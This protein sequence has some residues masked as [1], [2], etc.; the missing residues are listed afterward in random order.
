MRGYVT[1]AV[2]DEKY[3][4]LAVNLLKSY[5]LHTDETLPFA[6]VCDRENKYTKMFDKTVIIKNPSRTYV[7]KLEILNLD[8]FNENDVGVKSYI[9][10]KL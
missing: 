5:R 4:K 10:L 7:D 6:I 9:F 1:L 2:G 8:I 3:Y